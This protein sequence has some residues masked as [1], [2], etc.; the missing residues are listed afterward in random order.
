MIPRR[1]KD[2]R[3][4]FLTFDSLPPLNP[5]GEDPPIYKVLFSD[6]YKEANLILLMNE[7]RGCNPE[8][9]TNES[10]RAKMAKIKTLSEL[11]DFESM[12]N[13]TL[14]QEG[15]DIRQDELPETGYA[16]EESI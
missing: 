13:E 2:K 4:K 9:E 14:T 8:L 1:Q 6:E 11:V 3:I 5:K 15:E 12:L 7:I 10:L 16:T